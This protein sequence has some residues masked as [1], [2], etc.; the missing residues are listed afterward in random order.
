[1]S[2]LSKVKIFVLR[3]PT[4]YTSPF[5]PDSNMIRS[6]MRK[7]RSVMIMN[8]DIIFANVSFAANATAKDPT[9]SETMME[10]TSF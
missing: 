5:S 2:V 9:P 3:N 10:L 6:P 7:G 4:S 1:M 8:P